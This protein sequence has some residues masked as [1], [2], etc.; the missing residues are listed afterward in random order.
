MHGGCRDP[1]LLSFGDEDDTE[2]D[3][4][5]RATARAAIVSSHEA[6]IDDPLL[7]REP[8]DL[9]TPAAT[10]IARNKHPLNAPDE[11]KAVEIEA[12]ALPSRTEALRAEA[13]RLEQELESSKDGRR[14]GEH[15]RRRND[16][17][18]QSTLDADHVAAGSA[19]PDPGTVSEYDV[20]TLYYRRRGSMKRAS[21]EE[22]ALALLNSFQRKLQSPSPHAT[23]DDVPEPA[24]AS[25]NGHDEAQ[26]WI[27]HKLH[28]ANEPSQG[29][30]E[31]HEQFSIYGM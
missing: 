1:G 9:A 17:A 8:L 20:A 7:A 19:P 29:R 24:V 18:T 6:L 28:F 16:G 4:D 25:S 10:T 13:A 30:A 23:T 12:K 11:P 2:G 31:D 5:G 22:D 14:R 15:E 21:R 3:G 26:D 27:H